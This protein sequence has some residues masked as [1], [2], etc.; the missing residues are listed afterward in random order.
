MAR[1]PETYAA[2]HQPLVEEL[3]KLAEGKSYY[4]DPTNEDILFAEV[5]KAI[6]Y[7]LNGVMLRVEHALEVLDD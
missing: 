5:L 7:T 1:I 2:H 3:T 6:L 4:M